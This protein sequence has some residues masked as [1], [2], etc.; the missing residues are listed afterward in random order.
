MG[1]AVKKI[2]SCSAGDTGDPGSIP[3]P[4]ISPR[5]GNGNHSSI[6]TTN[7][8]AWQATVQRVANNWTQLSD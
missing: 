6:L 8:G 5:G 7:R 2:V 4:G 1:S 3:G